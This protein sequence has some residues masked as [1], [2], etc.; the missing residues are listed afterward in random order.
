M[1]Y[2]VIDNSLGS[3]LNALHSVCMLSGWLV[4]LFA[5]SQQTEL[6]PVVKKCC[7]YSVYY[8]EMRTI[9]WLKAFSFLA[10]FDINFYK[11]VPTR[12]NTGT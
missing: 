4:H 10:N 7:V 12:I 3:G 2:I 1:S 8:W 11:S 6:P 5:F 9:Q